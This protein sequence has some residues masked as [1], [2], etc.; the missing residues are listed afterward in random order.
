MDTIIAG[1]ILAISIVVAKKVGEARERKRIHAWL[2][3]LA[4]HSDRQYHL[5]AL[6]AL[7]S[8]GADRAWPQDGA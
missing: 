1:L 5:Q 4:T 8:S 2:R 7:I 6:A 3:H